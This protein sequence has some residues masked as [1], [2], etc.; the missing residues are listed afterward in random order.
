MEVCIL[1]CL[2]AYYIF[3]IYALSCKT[4]INNFYSKGIIINE[5]VF[6][7]EI[8]MKDFVLMQIFQTFMNLSYNIDFILS[9]KYFVIL[10]KKFL[11]CNGFKA[12]GY[13]YKATI[14]SILDKIDIFNNIFMINYSENFR[15]IFYLEKIKSFLKFL[16]IFTKNI[17]SSSKV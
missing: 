6:Y 14:F 16:F 7:V 10:K 9:F 12:L 1:N 4:K 15:F 3:I 13:D 8:S 2:E 11:Q 5:D 17:I